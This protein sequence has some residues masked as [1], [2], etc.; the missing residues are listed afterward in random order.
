MLP[1]KYILAFLISL[2]ALNAHQTMALIGSTD[3]FFWQSDVTP[4]LNQIVV[5]RVTQDK[6]GAVWF[7]TQDGINRFD[8]KR[9]EVYTAAT[10]YAGGL[11]P[12]LISGMALDSRDSLWVATSGALQVFN[13][14]TKT[15]SQPTALSGESLDI[16]SMEIDPYGRILLGLPGE[17]GIY[18]QASEQFYRLKLPRNIAGKETTAFAFS[19]DGDMYGIVADAGVF[20]FQID[21]DNLTAEAVTT[22]KAVVAALTDDMTHAHVVP[23]RLFITDTELWLATQDSGVYVIGLD[24][25]QERH[26]TAGPNAFDLP[27]NNITALFIEEGRVWIGTSAGLAVSDDGGRTFTVYTEFNNGLADDPI[28]SIYKTRDDTYWVGTFRGLMQARDS[29]VQ[30]LTSKNS[31]LSGDLVNA[32]LEGGDGTIWVGTDSGLNYLLPGSHEFSPINSFTHFELADDTVMSLAEQENYIWIGTYEGG[33]YRLNITTKELLVVDYNSNT[34]DALN[35]LGITS[36]LVLNDNLIAAGTF[37]GGVSIVRSDGSVLRT[38]RALP[39]SNV[40]DAVLSLTRDNDGQI[41]VGTQT[42]LA[43]IDTELRTIEPLLVSLPSSD[44]S[45]TDSLSVPLIVEI[46]LGVDNS[47]W[48]S[49]IGNGLIRVTRDVTNHILSAANLSRV[50]QLPS[51]SI[52][53]IHYDPEGLVWLAHTKGLTRFNPKSL[54][55]QQVGTQFGL[56]SVEFSMGASARGKTGR[57]YFGSNRGVSSLEAFD[58]DIKNKPVEIGLSSINV[59]GQNISIDDIKAG[60]TLELSHEDLIATVEFFAAEYI[61]PSSIEYAYR[62]L[63]LE[64]EWIF[65][66]NER[67]VSLTTLPP[68]DYAL[69]LA[70]RGSAGI[71]NRE[72]LSIPIMV[73]PAWWQS[74]YA[75]ASYAVA[76]LLAI[77]LIIVRSRVNLTAARVREQELSARVLE[78]TTDLEHAKR[79]AETANRAKSEFLAVMSHEIR[80]PLHGIIGMNELLLKTP[81]TP[82]QERFARAALNSGKTL[83]HLI[84]EVL[85]LAKIEADRI[86]IESLPFDL[87]ELI[88]EVCYLQGE[89]AQRKGLKLNFIPDVG[90]AQQYQG[91]PQKIRQIVMNLV[92]NAIKFTG[93]GDITVRAIQGADDD[94]VI[95]V[96]D[97]GIGIESE[98]RGRIFDKF[99]QVDASITRKYGGTGLGLTICRNFAS[100]MGGQL[101]I[102]DTETGVGTLIQVR[103]PLPRGTDKKQQQQQGDFALLTEDDLLAE[104]IAQHALRA[105]VQCHRIRSLKDPCLVDVFAVMADERLDQSLLDAIEE[106]DALPR[107][108]FLSDIRSFSPRLYKNAWT[109]LHKPITQGN[110]EE[111]LF[112]EQKVQQ[113]RGDKRRLV[114]KVLV[115]EDNK[116]NQLLANEILTSIG[117]TVTMVKNGLEA[118][119]AYSQQNF[120][121]ILMDCQMPVMDGFEASTR[122]RELEHD[123][124]RPPIPIIALTAAASTQEFKQ[125]LEQGMSAFLT[126]PCPAEVLEDMI[127][128]FLAPKDADGA[129]LPVVRQALEPP[130]PS[131]Q[132]PVDNPILNE[133]TLQ[134]ILAVN[135]KSG[136]QLLAK[137]IATFVEQLPKYLADLQ[138]SIDSDDYELLRKRSHGLK[139]MGLNIGAER[140]SY[141]LGIIEKRCQGD[142]PAALSRAEYETL[143]AL[144]EEAQ[145]SLT[146][147]Q[148]LHTP[149]P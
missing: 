40:S 146:A 78:R 71:W 77:L 82:Q 32:V 91:D 5:E 58:A 18:Q 149:G 140:L 137:V 12:G 49:S 66:G 3:L 75:Y 119:T 126:K 45:D 79:E 55:A 35:S 64:D 31:N 25:N 110:L 20:R 33:L 92:G 133:A 24:Q 129:E 108:I 95:A 86:E 147:W 125:A 68:G 19:N 1:I 76:L 113:A 134:S 60:A 127:A 26:I 16:L 4:Q 50:L 107:R 2:L 15:F 81:T 105:G 47:L 46:T 118:V 61:D 96:W 120:D 111:A 94:I 56:K 85:D 132:H 52:Y 10:E 87:I 93:Q 41:L 48:L 21:G 63:G 11:K 38:I 36:L 13:S 135:A 80:T 17:I 89:P 70:A 143:V 139:S 8:G 100:L 148:S 65:K 9:V 88:D 138:Q 28:F 123:A 30:T 131:A 97:T 144:A 145:E 130:T 67:T 84:S 141:Q 59:M 142:Q 101:E 136:A 122:I 7:A 73:S 74:L 128:G 72:G 54:E 124:G 53:A 22:S 116:V 34:N 29:V 104:S 62:I 39:G 112:N 115:A 98:A 114:G 57:L 121:I 109:A 44:G 42:G 23:R 103:L 69:Q 37:G 99:T 117:L 27:T 51:L 83:L 43:R 102:L 106:A 6:T 90:L 14:N